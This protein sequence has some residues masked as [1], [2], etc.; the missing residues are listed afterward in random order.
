MAIITA[1]FIAPSGG[2]ALQQLAQ[3][4]LRAG[5][6]IV[7]D[8]YFNKTGTWSHRPTGKP[9]REVT[10]IQSE[11][12]EAFNSDHN[13]RFGEGEFRRNL[14]TR[15]V[16]LNDLVGKTFTVGEVKLRGIRLC[17]PCAYLGELLVKEVVAG[18][19]HKGGLRAQI[20]ND[21]QIR[22]GDPLLVPTE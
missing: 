8:R 10:L 9:D 19:L 14:V 1:I 6:G 11:V 3:A 2:E 7:G 17:E 12:I 21:G 15:G 13:C 5:R 18:L 20:L 4:E 16:T 22:E